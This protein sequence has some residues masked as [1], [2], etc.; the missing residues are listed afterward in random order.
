MRIE[1]VDGTWKLSQNK[2]DA[3][4]LSAAEAVA[5]GIGQELYALSALMRDA[6]AGADRSIAPDGPMPLES[7]SSVRDKVFETFRSAIGDEGSG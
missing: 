4:R 3:V 7:E 6:R 5:G 1:A 2:P